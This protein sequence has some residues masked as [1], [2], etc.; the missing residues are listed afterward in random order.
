MKIRLFHSD[1]GDCL[2]IYGAGGGKLLSD[3]GMQESY[4]RHVAHH[5]EKEGEIDLLCV[6]HVDDDHIAGV[7]KLLN[8]AFEWKIF[9][10]H[11]DSGD[12]DFKQPKVPKPPKI[13]R[14][15]HN[16]FHTQVDD[17]KGE[18]AD[19]LAAMVPILADVDDAELQ[20]AALENQA[21]VTSNKQAIQ[22]SQRLKPE[23]LD[24]PLN[25]NDKLIMVRPAKKKFTFGSLD[26]RIV[27]PFEQD[28]ESFRE[29]WNIWL[30]ENKALVKELKA[31]ARK[32]AD[33][34]DLD[35]SLLLEPALKA[36]ELGKR[37]AVT[38]PNLASIMLFV[39]DGGKTLLLTG[40]GHANEALKGLKHLGK[41]N[42]KGAIHLDV[43]KVPHHGSEH[44]M[45]PEFAK[46]VTAD[47]YLFCG[48]G[49]KSNPE[50]DVV[51]LLFD[52]RIKGAGPKKKFKFWFNASSA[53]ETKQDRKKYMK[54]MEGFTADLQAES[55]RLD[56]FFLDDKDFVDMTI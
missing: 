40:D 36:S 6:S 54:F 19:M 55:N 20:E 37:S 17:N 32:D 35:V 15:W 56:V 42:S 39:E 12:D 38:P 46:K 9:Q 25:E 5:L 28:L 3:G 49:F 30:D 34:L 26:C 7:L 10:A 14:I 51:K 48:N 43:L 13:K 45:T 47:H 21:I 24:I 1:K 4:V 53:S 2:M 23:Q 11:K 8:D 41:L 27:A 22:V 29:K 31:K 50:K 16:A 33:K 44:N 52:E 18:I